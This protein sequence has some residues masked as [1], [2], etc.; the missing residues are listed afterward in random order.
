[1]RFYLNTFIWIALV[2]LCLFFIL[3]IVLDSNRFVIRRYEITSDKVLK[4]KSFV[5]VSDLHGKK[6]KNNNASVIKCI[7][8]LNPDYV[9]LGGDI[10]T[11]YPG[12][13]FSAAVDFVKNLSENNR[14]IYA[15]GNH[16]YRAGLYPE[17]Y[18][19]M[20]SDYKKCL[21]EYGVSLSSNEFTDIGDN[22]RVIS[23]S[24]ESPYYKRFKPYPMKDDYISSLLGEPDNSKFNIMLAHNPDYFKYYAGYG[25]DLSLSG[26]VHGGVV[27]IPGYRGVIS[28]MWR[29]FPHYDGGRFDEFEKTMIVNRGLG[30]HTIKLRMFNPGEIVY[31]AVKK[32]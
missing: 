26:H 22:Y 13:D 24:L 15:Y 25:A 27:R 3:I 19:T 29:L 8:D 18:G 7:N 21:K 32:G 1:M 10:M 4:D 20:L 28:P 12:T 14:I 11:A 6:Y 16:E 31:I 23:L 5:F 30:M 2:V 17:V 9:L